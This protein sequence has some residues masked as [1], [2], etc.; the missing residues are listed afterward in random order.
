MIVR[1][2]GPRGGPGMREMLSPSAALVGLGLWDKVLLVT[3]GRFS[4]GTKGMAIGHVEPEAMLGG[5][6]GL[7]EEGD[8][9]VMDLERKRI[10]VV[11]D[12]RELERRRGKWKAAEP[13]IGSG[14]LE[15][16]GRM[17]GPASGG[18]ILGA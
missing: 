1:Y 9:V 5:P 6:I 17:V 4:G 11:A 18:A 2:E 15:R 12:E 14:Y 10:D 13:K 16:Y 8:K 7:V 3:D